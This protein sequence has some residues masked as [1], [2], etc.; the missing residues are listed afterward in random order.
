MRRDVLELR[1]FY[2]TPLGGAARQ[3]VSRK[4]IEAWGDGHDLDVLGVGYATP[5]LETFRA[6]G[7]RAVAAMPAGQGVEVWPAGGRVLSCLADEAALPFANALF[8]RV[9]VIH[10]LEEADDPLA[11][12]R[13]VW[14]V[15]APAGRVIVAAANRRGFW[16][17]AE[18]TPFGHGRPFTRHQLEELVQEAEL[19]PAAWS[20]ALFTPPLNWAA[21]WAEGFERTGARLWPAL[22][23]L[24]LLEAV[25]QTFAVKPKGRRATVRAF[26]P[27]ALR[28]VPMGKQPKSGDRA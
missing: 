21:G 23:G 28:P 27:G 15:L 6:R 12:M 10:A 4:L 1:D 16:A 3:A 20:R 24:I 11:L 17:G 7:R 9:L 18:S 26:A 2:A 25:K 22:S 14:R 13:E 8:D 5:F 19:H